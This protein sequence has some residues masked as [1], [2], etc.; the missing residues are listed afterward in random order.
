MLFVRSA[1][2]TGVPVDKGLIA[3]KNCLA[4]IPIPALVAGARLLLLLLPLLLVEGEEAE[5]E[6]GEDRVGEVVGG[7]VLEE[8]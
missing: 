1:R 7:E 4:P 2:S 8:V 5:G 3:K 6:G